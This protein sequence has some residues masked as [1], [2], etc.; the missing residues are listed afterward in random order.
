MI[1]YVKNSTKLL[2]TIVARSNSS[3]K[4]ICVL[5]IKCVYYFTG[6]LLRLKLWDVDLTAVKLAVDKILHKFF[7]SRQLRKKLIC[8]GTST[9]PYWHFN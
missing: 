2:A 5:F 9:I 1:V 4:Y 8:V 3:T 6:I 7:H